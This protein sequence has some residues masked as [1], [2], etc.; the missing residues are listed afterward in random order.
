MQLNLFACEPHELESKVLLVIEID[1]EILDIQAEG[2]ALNDTISAERK[3]INARM[4]DAKVR[5]ATASKALYSLK[6]AGV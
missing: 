2:K 5:R 1:N 6:K 4:K 3:D